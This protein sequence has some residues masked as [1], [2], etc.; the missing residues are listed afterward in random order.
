M[1]RAEGKAK[2]KQEAADKI[3]A[4]KY[5]KEKAE[6][7]SKGHGWNGLSRRKWYIS[8]YKTY[9]GLHCDVFD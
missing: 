1:N 7:L 9:E 3:A 8:T 4:D 5:A 2:R 6:A